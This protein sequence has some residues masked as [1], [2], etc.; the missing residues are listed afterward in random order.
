MMRSSAHLDKCAMCTAAKYRVS[1][2]KSRSLTA[3]MLLGQTPPT[4][5]S[6]LAISC[7]STPKGF[8]AKAPVAN[9]IDVTLR[10]SYSPPRAN[11]QRASMMPGKSLSVGLLV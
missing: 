6:S 5:P 4:K 9:A 8:P 2:T 1:S 3:S 11:L 7:L 10:Q